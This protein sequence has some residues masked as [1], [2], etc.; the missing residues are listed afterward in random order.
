MKKTVK[1]YKWNCGV[2]VQAHDIDEAKEKIESRVRNLLIH[3]DGIDKDE[4]EVKE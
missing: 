3:P 4:I 1:V 2:S